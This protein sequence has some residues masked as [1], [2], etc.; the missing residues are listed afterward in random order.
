M[1]GMIK[2]GGLFGSGRSEDVFEKLLP[3]QLYGY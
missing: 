2:K 3:N 1:T